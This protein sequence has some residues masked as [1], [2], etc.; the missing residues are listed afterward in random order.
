MSEPTRLNP[1]QQRLQDELGALPHDRPRFPDDLAD[2]LRHELEVEI[3]PLLAEVPEA[4]RPLYVSKHDLMSVHGCEARF[5]AEQDTEFA[6]TVPLA[7]GSVAH[8]AIE[9]MVTWRGDPQPLDLVEHA[10]ARLEHNERS[11][12]LFIQSLDEAERAELACAAND[13][14]ATFQETFPPLKRRWRPVAESR[15]RADLCRDGL[16][17]SGRIDL[18]LGRADGNTAGKVVIDLKTGRAQQGHREDLRFYA[19]LETL[20]V[21]IPPRLLVSYYLDAGRPEIEPVTTELLD[22]AARRVADGVE[23]IVALRVAG[24]DAAST[25]P[26]GGCRFC[27]LAGVCED[28]KRFLAGVDRDLDLGPT[29]DLLAN[30]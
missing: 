14:V 17:L 23:K 8:K 9:L 4:D 3:A 26:S 2:R 16:A 19:L 29:A 20:K 5:V 18:S 10:M 13:F 28:G 21:G 15:V 6:W 11:V 7:R 12:G 1:A 22:A 30:A 24:A 27:P 25:A